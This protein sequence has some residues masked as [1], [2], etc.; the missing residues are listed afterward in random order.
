VWDGET[1]QLLLKLPGHN[2]YVRPIVVWSEETGDGRHDRIAT[3]DSQCCVRVWDGEP[4]DRKQ[5]TSVMMVMMI[6][7]MTVMMTVTRAGV[8]GACLKLLQGRASWTG[9]GGLLPFETVEGKYRLAS[10][11]LGCVT[12]WDL[13][14]ARVTA[15]FPS[16]ITITTTLRMFEL[17]GHYC[18]LYSGAS[19]TDRAG[20]GT[21]EL[22]DLG[23][24]PVRSGVRPAHK[25]G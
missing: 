15:E 20:R 16:S 8:T 10:A 22:W 3:S 21:L 7:M 11:Y 13:E 25:R 6:M 17:E 4:Y 18:L 9:V 19:Y 5:A 1:G 14:E 2:G 23:P 12:V 24:V